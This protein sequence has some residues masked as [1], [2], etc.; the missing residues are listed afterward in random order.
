MP[1]IG[2]VFHHAVRINAEAGLALRLRLEPGPNVHAGGIEPREE[3]LLV[4]VR[5]VDEI[6]CGA[7]KFLVHRLHPFLSERAG[8][9]AALL[10]PFDETR[11]LARHIGDG[12]RAVILINAHAR[13]PARAASLCFVDEWACARTA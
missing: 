1:S 8:I 2:V 3:R 6:H 7:E 4:Q 12:R 13:E 9:G 11:I 10:A 5:A